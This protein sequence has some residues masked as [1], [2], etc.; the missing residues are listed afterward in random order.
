MAMP[1]VMLTD[2]PNPPGEDVPA[3]DPRVPD[4]VQPLSVELVKMKA[5]PLPF[6]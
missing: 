1:D 5:R 3:M 6:A 2:T 4:T